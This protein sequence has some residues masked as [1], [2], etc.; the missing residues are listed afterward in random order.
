MKTFFSDKA[1]TSWAFGKAT[2]VALILSACADNEVTPV[3]PQGRNNHGSGPDYNLN[4]F[5]Q[6]ESKW[7]FGF[8]RFRQYEY[9][10]Q[11]IQGKVYCNR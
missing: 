7:S 2:L 3:L 4:V 9:E 5:L 11:M 10:T 8:L 1:A 6:G